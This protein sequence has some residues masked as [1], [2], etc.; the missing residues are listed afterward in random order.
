MTDL[1]LQHFHLHPLWMSTEEFFFKINKL[2]VSIFFS[3]S[4]SLGVC[5]AKHLCCQAP[6]LPLLLRLSHGCAGIAVS[7]EKVRSD[8]QSTT[9]QI[10]SQEGR[11]WTNR[12]YII[13]EELKF[14]RVG[15]AY[16]WRWGQGTQGLP[17]GGGGALSRIIQ[18]RTE[19]LKVEALK[20]VQH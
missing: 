7:S 18:H 15:W 1:Q 9:I 6:L 16:R 5:G 3:L 13:K 4:L 14:F 8:P 20:F 10:H 12:I 11:K 19:E 17:I 2:K